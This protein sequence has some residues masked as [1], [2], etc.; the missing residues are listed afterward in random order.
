V[1]EAVSALDVSVQAQILQLL[2]ELQA[3]YGLSYMFVTHD[4]GVVRL[5]A[6]E[7]TV[8]Q[9][10]AVVESGPAE[11]VLHAPRHAYTRQLLEAIPGTRLAVRS[12][13]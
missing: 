1:G 4:L 5:I 8:M 13:T 6:D 7:V 3:E 11:Q 10:G 2:V 9:D 12:T